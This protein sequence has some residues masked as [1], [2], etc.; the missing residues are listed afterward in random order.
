MIGIV[1]TRSQYININEF[2]ISINYGEK[3]IKC[4]PLTNDEESNYLTIYYNDNLDMLK[5]VFHRIVELHNNGCKCI[6][7]ENIVNEINGGSY[8]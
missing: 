3:T 5:K 4:Y 6:F 8:E 7:I 2:L 1:T